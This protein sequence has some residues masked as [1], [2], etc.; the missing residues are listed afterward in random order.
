MLEWLKN[1]GKSK[2]EWL[3]SGLPEEELALLFQDFKCLDPDGGT[4]PDEVMTYVVTGGNAA[5]LSRLAADGDAGKRLSLRCHAGFITAKPLD[6]DEFFRITTITDPA[7]HLRLAL[8]YEA[9]LKTAGT[10]K[11]TPGLPTGGEWLEIYLWEATRT[12][13]NTYPRRPAE[14]KLSA[15]ALET[16]LKLSG[17][18]TSWLTRA[19]LITEG[20]VSYWGGAEFSFMLLKVPEAA[21][22]FTSHAE[23]VRSCLDEVDHRGK[24]HIIDVLQRAGVSASLLPDRAAALAVGSS[25]QVREAAA[26]WIAPTP[27]LILP[28]VKKLAISAEPEERAHAVRFLAMMGR[29]L[30]RPFLRERLAA[31]KAKRVVD[32]IESA[33]RSEEQA[34]TQAP[35]IDG[36]TMKPVEENDNDSA[37]VGAGSGSVHRG[38]HAP[39]AVPVQGNAHPH[40]HAQTQSTHALPE[41]KDPM[42]SVALDDSLLADLEKTLV[43][44]NAS[45]SATWNT[46]KGQRWAPKEPPQI[47]PEDARRWFDFL[48][49]PDPAAR[50]SNKIGTNHGFGHGAA[51]LGKVAGHPKFTL[52]HALRWCM[53]IDDSFLN[54][55]QWFGPIASCW[56]EWILNHGPVDFLELARVCARLRVQHAWIGRWWLQAG[57]FSS[58]AF[59]AQS[60]E[61]VWPYFAENLDTLR[62]ILGWIPA[63]PVKDEPMLGSGWQ[64]LM[65]ENAWRALS[66][67]PSPP[68]LCMERMWEAA[69][70]TSKTERALAQ[71][72]LLRAPDRDARI[73]AVLSTGQMDARAAAAD[74][75]GR[76]GVRE[77]IPSLRNAATKEKH[78]VPKAAMLKALER[79]GVPPDEF[80]SRKTLAK[81]TAKV[82]AKGAPPALAWLNFD[83]LPKVHWEDSGAEVER[84]ILKAW[85]IQ[86]CKVKSSEPNPMV[87]AYAAMFR[88]AE[89]EA[90]GQ[91]ILEAWMHA[92]LMPLTRA[93]AEA[94]ATQQAQQSVQAAAKYP[95]YYT[96][97]TFEEFYAQY[98]AAMLVRPHGSA[99]DSKGVLAVAGA[100]VGGGAAAPIAAYLKKWYGTRVHQARALLQMLSWV[101]HPAA[102]QTLL[103]IGTRFRTKSLQ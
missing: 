99:S 83:L 25:R 39:A 80:L 38:S 64:N 94:E 96:M 43:E 89:R 69:L 9:A 58:N 22:T 31:D 36:A 11:L 3:R 4:L 44:A 62:R 42:E 28:E 26:S 56:D 95:Q 20:S 49:N 34:V 88:P 19:A 30:M 60:P 72:A 45:F 76:L 18:P 14:T 35:S 37:V 97:H 23:T 82:A 2:P 47:A 41:H 10:R 87:R 75:L 81:D 21:S 101:D 73:I 6:R 51:I 55:K 100:C 13:P 77:A 91:Y 70:G 40:A 68:P 66:G 78:D 12:A 85:L 84:D 27:D 1:L 57:T 17:H 71:A 103:S 92:D 16:M 54:S 48:R 8:V 29:E 63:D 52:L 53:V 61:Q 59:T 90:L 65:R 33:L 46:I 79:L 93:A 15:P 24:A 98:L 67:F 7:F 74:W 50:P 86:A 5:V 32:A 102:T